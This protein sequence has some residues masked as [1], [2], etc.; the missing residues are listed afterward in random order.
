[1]FTDKLI[2]IFKVLRAVNI[3]MVV[4]WVVT[5]SSDLTMEAVCSTNI[6]ELTYGCT[7]QV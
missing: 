3:L 1:M 7:I 2:M 4:F 5:P 6:D